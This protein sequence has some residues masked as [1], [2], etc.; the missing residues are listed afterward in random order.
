M[1]A[2]AIA[3]AYVATL[4]AAVLVWREFRVKPEPDVEVDALRLQ[5]AMDTIGETLAKHDRKIETL[6]AAHALRGGKE[7]RA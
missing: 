5:Q 7:T 6:M 1:I 4:A 3:L 2:I